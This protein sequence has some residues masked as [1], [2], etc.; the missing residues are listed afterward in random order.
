MARVFRRYKST[1]YGN[2]RKSALIDGA[3]TG[4]CMALILLVRNLLSAE[5]MNAPENFITEV[6]LAVG[7]FWSCYQYRKGLEGGKVTLKELMLLGRGI[8]VVGGVLYGLLTWLY[9]GCINPERVLWYNQHYIATIQEAQTGE[10]AQKAV[11]AVMRYTAGNWGVIAGF[12]SF[13][14]SVLL[15]FFA[16]LLFRTEKGEVVAKK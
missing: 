6:V 10:E 8:G 9:C 11:E 16:A 13:V 2:Y 7:I 12:R 3:L 14:W 15:A 5:P 4:A 1:I